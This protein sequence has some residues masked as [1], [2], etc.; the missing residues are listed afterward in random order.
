MTSD[1]PQLTTS[2]V[3]AGSYVEWGPIVAGS[4]LVLALSSVL[5]AFGSAVG[6]AIVSPWSAAAVATSVIW[7]GSFW[8]LLVQLW[9]FA[10]GGYMAGRM[11]HR[12]IGASETE[13]HFR[14][15]AHGLLVWGL[16]VILSVIIGTL[17]VS[18]T[19]RVPADASG[20]APS[21]RSISGAPVTLALDHLFRAI[22]QPLP[23]AVAVFDARPEAARLLFASVRDSNMAAADRAYLSQLVAAKTGLSQAEADTRVQTVST[24]LKQTFERLRKTTVLL[25]FLAAASLLVGAATA[26]WAAVT[27]GQHRDQGTI[28]EGLDRNQKLWAWQEIIVAKRRS[29]A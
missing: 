13:V 6:L 9:S 17:L 28:W 25:G 7:G 19:S 12:W 26:W 14:D 1:N 29:G 5:L 21:A 11:R 27:G 15:G 10:L 2:T 24:Q 16:S 18:A 4:V 8:F 20:S 23:P 22:T 3:A